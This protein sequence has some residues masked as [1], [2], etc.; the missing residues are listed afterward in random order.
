[1]DID[2]II[3]KYCKELLSFDSFSGRLMDYVSHDR[4]CILSD[5]SAGRP[6]A[7]GYENKYRGKWYSCRPIDNTPKCDCGLAEILAA[8]EEMIKKINEADFE[9]LI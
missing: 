4:E 3:L 5:C 8:R 2:S 9:P 7:D 6:T 1:M